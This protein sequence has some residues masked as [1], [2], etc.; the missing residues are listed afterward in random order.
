MWVPAAMRRLV[1]AWAP[2]YSFADPIATI[3]L[4]PLS[5]E[6]RIGVNLALGVARLTLR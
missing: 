1:L 5:V 4:Q 6:G 2:T 3:S